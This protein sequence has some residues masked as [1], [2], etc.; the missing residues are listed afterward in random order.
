MR[1]GDVSELLIGLFVREGVG[2][3]GWALGVVVEALGWEKVEVG[4]RGEERGMEEE[5]LRNVKRGGRRG[6][7]GVGFGLNWFVGFLVCGRER[8]ANE[9]EFVGGSR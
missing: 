1:R 2:G 7:K 8:G 4:K 9:I 6:K 5:G 3:V